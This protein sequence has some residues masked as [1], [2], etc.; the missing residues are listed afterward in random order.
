VNCRGNNYTGRVNQREARERSH[1]EADMPVEFLPDGGFILSRG[2]R[3]FLLMASSGGQRLSGKELFVFAKACYGYIDG[4]QG[5][6]PLPF[7]R[8]D[9]AVTQ[10]KSLDR[11]DDVAFVYM[12]DQK[13]HYWEQGVIHVSSL[14]FYQTI[15]NE[16]ARDPR[17]GLGLLSIFDEQGQV[18][19]MLRGGN[20]SY[21]L[22]CT[23]AASKSA[24]SVMRENFGRHLA[25]IHGLHEFGQKI[26]RLIGAERFEAGDVNY[27]D[28]K[29]FCV[30]HPATGSIR[31]IIG[32]GGEL[33]PG[34][35]EELADGHF[36]EI[37]RLASATTIFGKP[38]HF[39]FER[40]R[41]LA[42]HM[43]F[44]CTEQHLPAS[45]EQ[46]LPHIEF[47]E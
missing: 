41:R 27:A 4:I 33:T 34:A 42:F 29:C 13:R 9:A 5:R 45:S 24:R 8:H 14:S 20:A 36:D 30:A 28:S 23:M 32:G 7:A 22:C 43:P 1:R 26:A 18:N 16:R 6:R 44:D 2:G 40:E 15:E 25:K 35:L 31:S 38:R 12:D 3:S 19:L 21:V 39:T 10:L 37:E 46:F 11:E 17:E 47:V